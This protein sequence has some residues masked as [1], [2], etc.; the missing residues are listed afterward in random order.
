MKQL[1]NEEV[2]AK[3]TVQTAGVTG[4]QRRRL[5]AGTGLDWVG[6][7]SFSKYMESEMS[8]DYR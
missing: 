1:S 2:R 6:L 3:N 8:T 4:F 5:A 7:G